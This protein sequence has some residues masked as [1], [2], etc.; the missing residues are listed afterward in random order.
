MM[1]GAVVQQRLVLLVALAAQMC[2]AFY[3]PGVAPSEFSSGDLL[4]IKVIH[5][6][7]EIFSPMYVVSGS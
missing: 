3:I 7:G 1:V 2:R 6:T 4:E 5:Q